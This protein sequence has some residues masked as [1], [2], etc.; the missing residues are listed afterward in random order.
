MSLPQTPRH[1]RQSSAVEGYQEFASP[2]R[3][4]SQDPD[5][6]YRNNS[7]DDTLEVGL[8]TGGG[9]AGE[10]GMGNLADELADAFSES[11]D[12]DEDEDEDDDHSSI[13]NDNDGCVASQSSPSREPGSRSMDTGTNVPI[14]SHRKV[15]SN[16][17]DGSEFGSEPDF[18]LPGVPPGLL[19][20][21]DAIESLARRGTENYGGST[22]D[23]VSRVTEALRDLGSQSSIEASASR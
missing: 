14:R 8:L 11:G 23:A 7:R 6:P 9:R 16:S 12:E 20:K 3:H 18:D 13:N 1:S 19:A 4:Q 21:I 5:T 22:D 17:Y 15:E 10:V 2:R